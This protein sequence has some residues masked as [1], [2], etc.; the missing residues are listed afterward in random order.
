MGEALQSER[1][2]NILGV[3]APGHGMIVS[4]ASVRST[5]VTPIDTRY[6][7]FFI[8]VSE[9]YG[10]SDAKDACSDL[11][12]TNWVPVFRLIR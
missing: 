4:M 2:P 9:M 12:S 3:L 10:G 11:A 6:N 8:Y 1:Y 7:T 5:M